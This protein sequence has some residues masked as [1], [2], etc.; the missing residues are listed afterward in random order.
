MERKRI[1]SNEIQK[2]GIIMSNT[3][4]SSSMI[5][6]PIIILFGEII[7]VKI[8]A[9][10]ILIQNLIIVVLAILFNSKK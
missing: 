3:L 8:L 1:N 10:F 6:L 4:L 5:L 7:W 2:F 9:S